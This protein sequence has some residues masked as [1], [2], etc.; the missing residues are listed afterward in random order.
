MLGRTINGSGILDIRE[1]AVA[2]AISH[3]VQLGGCHL[4][5]LSTGFEILFGDGK[6]DPEL[7]ATPPGIDARPNE[8][9]RFDFLISLQEADVGNVRLVVD[10]EGLAFPAVIHRDLLSIDGFD[11]TGKGITFPALSGE[12]ARTEGRTDGDDKELENKFHGV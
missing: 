5:H 8:K 1:F 7:I 9:A 4:E 12:F 3:L 11:D 2:I 10:R 6:G